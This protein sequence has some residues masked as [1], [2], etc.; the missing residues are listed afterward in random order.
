MK[1]TINKSVHDKDYAFYLS[2]ELTIR[3][4]L[5]HP[6]KPNTQYIHEKRWQLNL[7]NRVLSKSVS[8]LC[9]HIL[10][11]RDNVSRSGGTGHE[12]ILI[13]WR[14]EVGFK[15]LQSRSCN[16]TRQKYIEEQEYIILWCRSPLQRWLWY[17]SFKFR[18]KHQYSWKNYKEDLQSNSRKKPLDEWFN[19]M[20]A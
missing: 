4:K 10:Y 5:Y 6:H 18:H 13:C 12:D 3:L 8:M 2:Q 19:E 1:L 17:Q 14:M 15:L 20:P 9:Y 11:S 7:A 16:Y